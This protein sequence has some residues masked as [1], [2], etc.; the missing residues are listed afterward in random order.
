LRARLQPR[1]G[2][3]LP[4]PFTVENMPGNEGTSG[5]RGD[6]QQAGRRLPDPGGIAGS[7]IIAPIVR[8][9]PSV[10]WDAFE[11]IARVHGEEEF[12]FVFAPTPPFTRV[13]EVVAQPAQH[14]R[15]EFTGPS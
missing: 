4:K 11:P 1:A 12:L 13:D 14:G 8:N 3:L 15:R 10:K 5:R 6:A 7:T 9:S 2:P